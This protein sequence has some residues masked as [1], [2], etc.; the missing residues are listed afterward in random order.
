ML[1]LD[2]VGKWVAFYTSTNWK[3]LIVK[4]WDKMLQAGTSVPWMFFMM[5][6][7]SSSLTH[8]WSITVVKIISNGESSHFV[9]SHFVNS[10]FVNIGQMG[11][12]KMGIDNMGIDKVESWPNGNWRSGNWQSGNWQSGNW[13]SGNWQSGNN[14]SLGHEH[15]VANLRWYHQQC[16]IPSWCMLQSSVPLVWECPPEHLHLPWPPE[17][18]PST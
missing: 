5:C 11:I 3:V 8:K 9:N 15:I 12:D 4:T 16:I 13:K 18:Q 10:R 7:S 17:P 6:L 14:P 2:T 1:N